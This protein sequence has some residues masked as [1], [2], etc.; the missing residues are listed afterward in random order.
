MLTNTGLGILTVASIAVTGPFAQTN[1]CSA[2]LNPGASCTI[3]VTFTPNAS[4]TL[5]GAVSLSDNAPGSPQALSLT[6]T[7]VSPAL[8]FSPISLTFAD[9]TV[10]TISAAQNV[11][12]TNTGLGILTVGSIAATGQFA[13]TNTCA[14][15]LN[16][17]ASCTISAT[18]APKGKGTLT[19][20]VSVGD[21]A[22]GSPQKLPLAGTGTYM[23]FK[24]ANLS[25][26]TQPVGTD[27]LPKKIALT[28]KGPVTVNIT[29]ISIA[30]TDGGD[31]TQTNT[32]DKSVAS[33]TSCFITVTF[34]PSA[35]GKRTAVI[36]VSDNGGG[37]PQAAALS[38]AGT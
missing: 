38:G 18:F 1:T 25:F 28:N 36:A 34:T 29:K 10:F 33:G 7:G 23:Q 37:S 26:G 17:A 14:G 24:P 5:T 22:P 21:N 2:T 8:T 3:A 4:G 30:G 31:F 35:K 11:T 15:T 12:L 32:C 6:G 20:S 19:G 13:Q 16:P 9:Q 27:S